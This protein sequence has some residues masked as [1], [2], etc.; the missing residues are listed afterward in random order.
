[1]LWFSFAPIACLHY[2]MGLYEGVTINKLQKGSVASGQLSEAWMTQPKWGL[3]TTL[4]ETQATGGP[5]MGLTA[6]MLCISDLKLVESALT[7][8]RSVHWPPG[9]EGGGGKISLHP[10]PPRQMVPRGHT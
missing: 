10:H 9:Q 6:W 2:E 7:A 5:A 3:P 1:M 8:C 4:N